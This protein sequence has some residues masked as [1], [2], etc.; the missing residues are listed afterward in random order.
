MCREILLSCRCSLSRPL[1]VE[2]I[3]PQDRLILRLNC[4]LTLDTLSKHPNL[5][6]KDQFHPVKPEP[7]CDLVGCPRC[8]YHLQAIIIVPLPPGV[9]N[10]VNCLIVI[11]TGGGVVGAEMVMGQ[12]WQELIHK[13]LQMTRI[14]GQV[15]L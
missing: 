12:V 5:S 3:P 2:H 4:S 8:W 13:D 11:V 6:P 14:T 15:D 7:L 9:D 10:S 1:S